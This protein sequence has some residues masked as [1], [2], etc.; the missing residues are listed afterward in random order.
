ME[1]LLEGI[2]RNIRVSFSEEDYLPRKWEN[3]CFWE[4]KF[5]THPHGW[6]SSAS[7]KPC[8]TVNPDHWT[9]SESVKPCYTKRQIHLVAEACISAPWLSSPST[10]SALSWGQLFRHVHKGLCH[11]KPNKRST[12]A[13]WP[14]GLVPSTTHYQGNREGPHPSHVRRI[15][16][17]PNLYKETINMVWALCWPTLLS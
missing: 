13:I 6:T 14:R 7:A 10:S 16:P 9:L 15:C 5:A 11:T 2:Q 8:N 12:K 1:Y 17:Y 4:G 3:M